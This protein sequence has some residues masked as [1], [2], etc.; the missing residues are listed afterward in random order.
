MFKHERYSH[1]HRNGIIFA[2]LILAG[3]CLLCVDLGM[4]SRHLEPCHEMSVLRLPQDVLPTGEVGRSVEPNPS[5]CE[6]RCKNTPGCRWFNFWPDG[7]CHLSP[8]LA[9]SVY[10]H[11]VISGPV[12]CKAAEDQPANSSKTYRN[13][14]ELWM[15]DGHYYDFRPLMSWHPGT[16]AP[17]MKTMGTDVSVLVRIQHL[18]ERPLK[19]LHKYAVDSD[20]VRGEIT[21]LEYRYSFEPD[22]FYMTLKDRV[23]KQL[24]ELGV[25]KPRQADTAILAKISFNL[26]LWAGTWYRIVFSPFSAFVSLQTDMCC[27]MFSS[28]SIS[29]LVCG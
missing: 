6:A 17:L 14:Q 22:G 5:A 10:Q 24:A 26:L 20:L 15:V 29:V 1:L 7:G 2:T 12:V 27:L 18:S 19:A 28:G 23:N 8:E 4:L 9:A 3:L 25:K 13:A 11:G 16:Q 21:P